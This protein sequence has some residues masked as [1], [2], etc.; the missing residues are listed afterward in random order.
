MREPSG[1]LDLLDDP[2][3]FSPRK[4]QLILV[5]SIDS[6]LVFDGQSYFS[7]PADLYSAPTDT[8][9]KVYSRSTHPDP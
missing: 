9:S 3:L 7:I 1:A 5:D 8:L 4:L 6:K 2:L